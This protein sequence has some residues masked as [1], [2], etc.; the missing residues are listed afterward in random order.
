MRGNNAFNVG[1]ESLL[2]STVETHEEV[3]SSSIVEMPLEEAEALI[4]ER[5][6]AALEAEK[7]KSRGRPRKYN[8]PLQKQHEGRETV[9]E[10]LSEN[11]G[12]D[13]SAPIP[14]A[15]KGSVPKIESPV[16]EYDVDKA[17]ALQRPPLAFVEP[18]EVTYEQDR[19]DA[20]LPS[21]GFITDFVNTARGME[22]PTLFL[23]WGA[24]WALSTTLARHAW[25]EWYP[26]KLWPN[27]YVLTVAP[28]ALC[29]KSTAMQI[30]VKMCKD[31]PEFLPSSI[32]RYEKSTSMITGKATSD[33]ILLALAPEE[34]TFLI[35]EN[36]SIKFVKKGSK[37]AFAV[38]ELT[39]LLNRQQYN[40]NLV[41]ALTDLYDSRDEDAELTR[42]R[43]REPLEDIYVTFIGATTPSSLKT[44]MPE[45]A[46]GGGFL[47]R[48]IIAFQDIPT[49]IYSIPRALEGYPIPTDIT[50]RLAWISHNCRGAY[51][52]TKEA[53]EM[54]DGHYKRWKER[55]FSNMTNEMLA[56]T[57]YDVL[58]LKLALLLRVQEYRVGNEITEENVRNAVLILDYTL[59]GSKAATEDLGMTDYARFMNQVRRIIERKGQVQRTQIQRSLSAKGCR[60]SDFNMI[61][62]QLIGEDRV[63]VELDGKKIVNTQGCG[64]ELYSLTPSAIAEIKKEARND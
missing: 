29:K 38:S 39:M 13:Y 8:T 62:S 55:M 31:A 11:S 41:T 34:R 56:E 52:L 32:E 1:L 7:Q 35:P 48:V 23:F 46:L 47:S 54:Y 60:V 2:G 57:R 64:R 28:P 10:A 20:L 63:S 59:S 49:K 16:Y 24:I 50:P 15:P 27:M 5:D 19:M 40:V 9:K 61:I 18:V 36:H 37:A 51:K 22:V 21:P 17:R 42:G 6:K 44:Q 58:L 45:E 53:F 14:K 4:A 12:G 33:G 3:F 25:L 26:D 43:G 30:A